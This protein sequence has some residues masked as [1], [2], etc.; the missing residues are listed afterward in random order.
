M[1]DGV[2]D[3][4]VVGGMGVAGEMGVEREKEMGVETRIPDGDE[5]GRMVL[6]IDA[7]RPGLS[8]RQVHA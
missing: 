3:E 7:Q 6:D 8:H 4:V 5:L 2:G 1:G